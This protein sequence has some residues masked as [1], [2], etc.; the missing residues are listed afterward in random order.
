[1]PN[2]IN[3]LLIINIGQP[4]PCGPY[5]ISF[6]G[7]NFRGGPHGWGSEGLKWTGFLWCDPWILRSEP[8]T[9]KPQNKLIPDSWCQGSTFMVGV[10]PFYNCQAEYPVPRIFIRIRAAVSLGTL[11]PL[12]H[13]STWYWACRSSISIIFI[14]KHVTLIPLTFKMNLSHLWPATDFNTLIYS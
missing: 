5:T 12:C 10:L 6:N 2:K 1:M 13:S 14:C 11:L 4:E 3:L 7:A 8:H 9:S